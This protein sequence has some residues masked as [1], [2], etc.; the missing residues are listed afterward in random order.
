[1]IVDSD[2]ARL[3]AEGWDICT[4][5]EPNM[6]TKK[7]SKTKKTVEEQKGW[8]GKIMPFELVKSVF[9]AAD[10]DKMSRLTAE[11]DN[12]ASE[13]ADIWENMDEGAKSVVCKDDD[14]TAFDAKKFKQAIKN[15]DL[16]KEAADCINAIQ[17]A[18]AKEKA[19]R[20][21]VK[22]IETGLDDKAKEKIE[23]L[24]EG[25]IYKLLESKWITPIITAITNASENVLAQFVAGFMTLEKK[26]SNPLAE[27][28][29]NIEKTNTELKT[30]LGELT[31]NVTD[32]MAVKM[33]MEEL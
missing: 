14:E 7:D 19:L 10:F 3:E 31:G 26:Y 32:M 33:L 15:G 23:S 9:F 13:Y 4:E 29:G 18:I 21:Q 1:M 27:L 6:V 30:S 2:L 17:D 5:T 12:K 24:S 20:K 16:D 22:T 25:E 8:K 28:S 11:A